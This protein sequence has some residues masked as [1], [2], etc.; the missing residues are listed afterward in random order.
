MKTWFLHI[1][2][3]AGHILSVIGRFLGDNPGIF[4][5]FIV[6][7]LVWLFKVNKFIDLWREGTRLCVSERVYHRRALQWIIYATLLDIIACTVFVIWREELIVTI[8]AGV[9]LF[10]IEGVFFWKGALISDSATTED[11]NAM[12]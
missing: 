1:L 2:S 8:P 7:F 10:L 5:L 12:T 6:I 11:M 9:A 3:A 4:A